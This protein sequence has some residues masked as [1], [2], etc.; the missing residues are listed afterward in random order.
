MLAIKRDLSDDHV[1][2][3]AI[4]HPH[5]DLLVQRFPESDISVFPGDLQKTMSFHEAP[6]S[7]AKWVFLHPR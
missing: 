6:K 4:D 2:S 7:V 3:D 1:D 5:H